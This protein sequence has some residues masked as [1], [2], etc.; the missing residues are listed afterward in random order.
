[1][2]QGMG[3][4]VS[5]EELPVLML[6]AIEKRPPHPSPPIRKKKPLSEDAPEAA[7]LKTAAFAALEER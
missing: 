5:I 7:E 4:K 1:M 3:E 2:K 6:L